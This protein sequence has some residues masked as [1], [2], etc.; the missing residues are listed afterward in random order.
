MLCVQVLLPGYYYWSSCPKQH[1]GYNPAALDL[2][3]PSSL[4]LGKL[5]CLSSTQN[6]FALAFHVAI[7]SGVLWV[8]QSPGE[9]LIV[10]RDPQLQ[11]IQIIQRGEISTKSFKETHTFLS[12]VKCCC[13]SQNWDLKACWV[14]WLH[15][16][17]NIFPELFGC[18]PPIYLFFFFPKE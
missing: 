9:L 13:K 11:E 6:L 5:C 10:T 16:N 1:I 18:S 17:G 4:H 2:F 14:Q 8:S 3:P 12:L 15:L 7:D